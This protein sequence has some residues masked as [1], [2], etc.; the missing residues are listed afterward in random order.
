[1]KI[2]LLSFLLL[3]LIAGIL[4]L[5]FFF[6]KKEQPRSPVAPVAKP[7]PSYQDEIKKD[8][9]IK[10]V[11]K[12]EDYEGGYQKISLSVEN[13]QNPTAYS[14]GEEIEVFVKDGQ[15]QKFPEKY[16]KEKVSQEITANDQIVEAKF[17]EKFDGFGADGIYE[18]VYVAV[19]KLE[20]ALSAG[21][22][23]GSDYFIII[24]N[25]Y[26]EPVERT[27]W[28]KPAWISE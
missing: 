25:D 12:V 22:S 26:L 24:Y 14:K 27:Y 20:E 15:V 9:D 3:G 11:K 17:F 6:L 23:L 21:D 10:E 18:N 13:P 16:I 4:V 1:M 5:G 19:A 8:F 7:A 28:S 2:K